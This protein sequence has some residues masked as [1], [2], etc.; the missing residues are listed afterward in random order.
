MDGQNHFLSC[1]IPPALVFKF[2]LESSSLAFSTY[3]FSSCAHKGSVLM[4][5]FI[6]LSTH[7]HIKSDLF[8]YIEAIKAEQSS[9]LR[10]IQ[11]HLK[12]C[13]N[14]KKLIL[15]LESESLDFHINFQLNTDLLPLYIHFRLQPIDKILQ[16]LR[17]STVANLS[18]CSEFPQ[19][20]FTSGERYRCDLFYHWAL[21][22]CAIHHLIIEQDG[23]VVPCETLNVILF[24]FSSAQMSSRLSRLIACLISVLTDLAW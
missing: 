5:R 2:F 24:Q 23:H 22:F 12:P 7:Y 3:M 21:L 10:Q 1:Y 19:S 15:V 4:L 18:V 8:Q 16:V 17:S 14:N 9:C 6:E 20:D 13:L 11:K